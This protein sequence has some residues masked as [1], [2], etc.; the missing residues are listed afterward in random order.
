MN[1]ILSSCLFLILISGWNAVVHAEIITIDGTVKSVDAKKRTITVESDTKTRSFDISSKAKVR[2]SGK[3]AS[4][5]QLTE[6][7]PVSLSFHDQLEV[8][9]GIEVVE[10]KL[11]LFNGTDL[12]GWGLL[13]H[14]ATKTPK[15]IPGWSMPI[16]K[17]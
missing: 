4:L 5:E 15:K 8:V 2:I 13:T 17:F 12:S 9:V 3:D 11:S 7:Q 16:E 1:R 10:E 14:K 6:L